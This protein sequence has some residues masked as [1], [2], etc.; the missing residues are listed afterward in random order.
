VYAAAVILDPRVDWSDLTDSKLLA[1][2][3]RSDLA[4]KI[5]RDAVCWAVGI[6][7]VEEIETI[8]ILQASLLA[9]K[10]AV[11]ALR[12]PPEMVLVDGHMKFK[13][14][15]KQET[16][17]KGDLRC[18]PISAAS[19]I[20]KVARDA[21]MIQQ[22]ILFPGYGFGKNKGYG[23]SYHQAAIKRLGVSPLHRKQFSG[24]KEY[25]GSAGRR[26]CRPAPAAGKLQNP[27]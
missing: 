9:M 27:S 14:S 20:A 19:I 15:W 7:S 25:L 21:F 12:H 10:R 4:V 13:G 22:D 11:E 16:L 3:E 8:N 1:P 6:S 17:V 5:R 23:T 26:V 2:E 24:V 18:Q